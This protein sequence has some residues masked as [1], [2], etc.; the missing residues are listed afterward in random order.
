MSDCTISR[1]PYTPEDCPFCNDVSTI[2]LEQLDIEQMIEERE[3][4][5]RE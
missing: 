3:S 5:D 4:Y 1:C 2:D